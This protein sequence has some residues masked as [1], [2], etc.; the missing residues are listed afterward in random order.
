[1]DR[2]GSQ[3]L[4]RFPGRAGV[5]HKWRGKLGVVVVEQTKCK[6]AKINTSFIFKFFDKRRQSDFETL[7]NSLPP[8]LSFVWVIRA[9]IRYSLFLSSV[10]PYCALFFTQNWVSLPA[11]RFR[12]WVFK[13]V[14]KWAE[15][16]GFSGLGCR[17]IW[18]DLRI[19][20]SLVVV[21]RK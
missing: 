2:A 6:L 18:F 19:V 5:A 3:I 7:E 8:I 9:S 11:F 4:E 16:L 14:G 20:W 1:M 21:Q 10:I 12:N 15:E 17:W 13:V